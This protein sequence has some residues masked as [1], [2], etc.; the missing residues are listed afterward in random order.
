MIEFDFLDEDGLVQTVDLA[1][2]RDYCFAPADQPIL[3]RLLAAGRDES[4]VAV[5]RVIA[6]HIGLGAYRRYLTNPTAAKETWKH[7][8]RQEKHLLDRVEEMERRLHV[9]S[10]ARAQEVAQRA[11]DA[12]RDDLMTHGFVQDNIEEGLQIT[13]LLIQLRDVAPTSTPRRFIPLDVSKVNQVP[14]LQ[15]MKDPTME[16]FILGF[17]LFYYSETGMMDGLMTIDQI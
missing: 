15:K 10:T 5:G 1:D 11:L 7:T 8:T 2:G 4:V 3:G 12:A 6:T 9:A 17:P 14:F 16:D 13:D